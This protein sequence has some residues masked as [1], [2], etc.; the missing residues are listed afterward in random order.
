MEPL[1]DKPFTQIETEKNFLREDYDGILGIGYDAL[2]SSTGARPPTLI[3]ALVE[4]KNMKDAFG[5]L[6]CGTL[7]TL[8]QGQ[9]A[10]NHH[11]GFWGTF[12]IHFAT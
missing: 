12:T 6:L 5:L 7:Q 1:E 3:S 4:Q 2:I 10:E 11:S 9:D 8:L